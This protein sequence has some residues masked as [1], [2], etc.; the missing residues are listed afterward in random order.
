M[1]IATGDVFCE[2]GKDDALPAL[3]STFTCMHSVV[4]LPLG[5]YFP[6][7]TIFFYVAL[8]FYVIIDVKITFDAFSGIFL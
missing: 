7:F 5:I 2:Q 1:L 4:K 3:L 6:S 8:L